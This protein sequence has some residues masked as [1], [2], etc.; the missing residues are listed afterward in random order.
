MNHDSLMW[1]ILIINTFFLLREFK[2][3]IRLSKELE[4]A[5][6]ILENR[7]LVAETKRVI[8]KLREENQKLKNEIKNYL[9]QDEQQS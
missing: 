8:S 4:E 2:K 6:E 1:A 5:N 3:S 7:G 9:K